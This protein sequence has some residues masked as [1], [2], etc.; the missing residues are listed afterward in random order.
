MGRTTKPGIREESMPWLF[1]PLTIKDTSL[2]SYPF[3]HHH[4]GIGTVGKMCI[5]PDL[6]LPCVRLYAD[7]QCLSSFTDE[8]LFS[9]KSF[10]K[11]FKRVWIE[12]G[13]DIRLYLERRCQHIFSWPVKVYE[14]KNAGGSTKPPEIT[15]LV[16]FPRPFTMDPDWMTKLFHGFDTAALNLWNV[17]YPRP[18]SCLTIHRLWFF[19]EKAKIPGDDFLYTR[20]LD[21]FGD[22]LD[23]GDVNKLG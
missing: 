3:H 19:K 11:T 8:E 23:K 4:P 22:M 7:I 10:P 12:N 6:C 20:E 9:A 16:D 1:V 15:L 17:Y 14:A 2:T 18:E 13:V 5:F 21:W